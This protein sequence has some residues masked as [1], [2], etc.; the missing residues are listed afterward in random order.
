MTPPA[1]ITQRDLAFVHGW[2]MHPGVWA[3]VTKALTPGARVRHV[4][5][6][7]HGGTP[8][9]PFDLE[10]LTDLVHGA[11]PPGAIL[12]GWS[13]GGL[14][15]LSLAR[16][17]PQSLGAVVLVGSTPCFAQ[18]PDWPHGWPQS[19]L[20]DFNRELEQDCQRALRSFTSLQA[21]GDAQARPLGRQ[22]AGLVRSHPPA[23]GALADGMAILATADLRGAV[24][25]LHVPALLIHGL[26]DRVIPAAAGHWLAQTLPSARWRPLAD[27]GHAPMLSQPQAVASAIADFVRHHGA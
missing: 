10:R 9:E 19:A 26:G 17:H 15:A 6:P 14:A 5:L 2:G 1:P 20:D 25:D 12:V 23:P 18:R 11:T 24:A 16:R 7:G 27:C 8:A 13:L 21:L 22:L 3:D 4:T